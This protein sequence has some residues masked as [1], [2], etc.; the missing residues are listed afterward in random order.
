[1][2]SSIPSSCAEC[3]GYRA[4]AQCEQLESKVVD[5]GWRTSSAS[6]APLPHALPPRWN[7]P[8]FAA[9]T[10]RQTPAATLVAP[11]Q[12]EGATLP[13]VRARCTHPTRPSTHTL[14]ASTPSAL[15]LQLPPAA[16]RVLALCARLKATVTRWQGKAADS[17]QQEQQ[18]ATDARQLD[19]L[20]G[21]VSRLE[22]Q[23]TRLQH[24]CT[25]HAA[26]LAAPQVSASQ[27]LTYGA[28]LL[29]DDESS[30]STR[31]CISPPARRPRHA[32]NSLRAADRMLRIMH[33]HRT[34]RSPG[35]THAVEACW[36]VG[37]C[38]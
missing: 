15:S 18:R 31:L 1:M 13:Q 29:N 37:G 38:P 11:F 7:Q 20:R 22:E 26:S 2:P 28:N 32:Y 23:R 33:T 36:L 16:G 25:Q 30:Q 19:E 9:A 10:H 21:E 27:P 17:T 24:Q 34:V 3:D 12:T 4:C 5:G 8:R 14:R 6:A 35:G